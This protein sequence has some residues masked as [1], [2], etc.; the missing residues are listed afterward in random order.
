MQLNP[1]IFFFMSLE[2]NIFTKNSNCNN[3]LTKEGIFS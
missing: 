3:K 1:E 2:L